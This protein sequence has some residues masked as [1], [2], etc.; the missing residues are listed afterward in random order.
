MY[1]VWIKQGPAARIGPAEHP[2]TV[3]RSTFT[4]FSYFISD[5]LKDFVS[6]DGKPRVRLECL[7]AHLLGEPTHGPIDLETDEV[8]PQFRVRLVVSQGKTVE[9]GAFLDF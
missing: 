7:E 8:R 4:C 1:P 2:S 5:L 9:I 3:R 6:R